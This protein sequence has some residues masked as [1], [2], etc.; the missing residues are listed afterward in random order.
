MELLCPVIAKG[1]NGTV[2]TFPSVGKTFLL[3]FVYF[4]FYV[5]LIF[6]ALICSHFFWLF[7]QVVKNGIK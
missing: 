1:F 2:L 7:Q 3:I 4:D 5:F 6:F